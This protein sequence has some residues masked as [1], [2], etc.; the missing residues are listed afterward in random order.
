MLRLRQSLLTMF[1]PSFHAFVLRRAAVSLQQAILSFHAERSVTG[2]TTARLARVGRG[3]TIQNP[4]GLE[5]AE[6]VTIGD[7]TELLLDEAPDGR[8]RGTI[9]LGRNVKVGKRVQL[10]AGMQTVRIGD[11]S[12]IHN[13]GI[14]Q[15]SVSIG[16]YCLLSCNVFI[17]SADHFFDHRPEWLVRDQDPLAR[18]AEDAAGR[19]VVVEDDCWIGWGAV[20]RRGVYIGKGAIIG[21]NSVVTR[22]VAPYTINAGAPCRQIGERLSFR[23]A[24]ELTAG[25]ERHWPYFYSGFLLH[26]RD[27]EASLKSGVV[28]A[29][30]AARV[31]LAGGSCSH[32][33][34]RGVLPARSALPLRVSLDGALLQT[35]QLEPGD[36]AFEIPVAGAGHAQDRTHVPA[37]LRDFHEVRLDAGTP[38]NSHAVEP[39]Y[40]IA[41]VVLE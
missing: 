33:R 36:F 29:G 37:V 18:A 15:G 32:L 27:L 7:G 12:S 3:V 25:L 35:V 39:R 20:I 11:D 8:S 40:G 34:V 14:L 38:A 17:S 9:A 13:G 4:D 22:D 28:F 26:Q 19:G 10:G 41:S 5:I 23:P 2:S 1:N 6:G 24:R 16:R 21:A 31:L 30:P